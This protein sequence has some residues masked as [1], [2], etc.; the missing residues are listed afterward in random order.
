MSPPPATQTEAKCCR[1]TRL[2]SRQGHGGSACPTTKKAELSLKRYLNQSMKST[3]QPIITQLAE[4][5]GVVGGGAS[6]PGLCCAAIRTGEA[7]GP[8]YVQV[9][10]LGGVNEHVQVPVWLRE[11]QK[12]T[13]SSFI[14]TNT[15]R[16]CC[17]HPPTPPNTR[18]AADFSN[19]APLME[20]KLAKQTFK[21]STRQPDVCERCNYG[22][23]ISFDNT[24][25]K[26]AANEQAALF[27]LA[28]LETVKETRLNCE[29]GVVIGG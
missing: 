15:T 14:R 7:G 26:L 9:E 8:G 25:W 22:R 3:K 21:H 4:T 11:Q 19:L 27:S 28:K 24:R 12:T 23:V 29:K 13:N 2:G 18:R 5:R 17:R 16:G 6:E 1:L 20:A 10:V